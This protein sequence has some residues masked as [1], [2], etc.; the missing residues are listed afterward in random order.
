[1][2][3]TK[4]IILVL[5]ILLLSFNPVLFSREKAD[6]GKLR[7]FMLVFDVKEYTSHVK[8][9]VTYFI[10]DVLQ[11]GDQLIIVSP[12][13]LV[14]FSLAKLS[15]PKDKLIKEIV[16]MLKEDIN[17]GMAR[18]R[19]T[20]KEMVQ[21]ALFLSGER[22]ISSASDLPSILAT[23][24]Q[25]RQILVSLR[26][27]LEERLMKFNKIFRRAKADNRENHLL[28]ISEKESRPIPEKKIIDQIRQSSFEYGMR[29]VE[30]FLMEKHKTELDFQ[31]IQKAFKYADIKFHFL[32]LQGKSG[33]FRRGIEYV[34]NSGDVYDAFSKLAKNTGGLKMSG[35]RPTSFFKKVDRLKKGTVEVE[36]IDQTM[37]KEDEK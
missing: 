23:Y 1:M 20:I 19:D 28:M 21:S 26:G 32:Y 4:V 29:A 2:S 10:N 31:K 11:E 17:R 9:A 35:S 12:K 34:D 3:K 5:W 14:G 13:K 24:Q 15:G 33:R 22:G 25:N 8:S 16:K 27:N 7:N 6:T 30:V 37:K 18:Y 36:V